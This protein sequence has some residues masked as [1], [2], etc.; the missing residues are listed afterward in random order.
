M[1]L[2]G[3]LGPLL[4]LLGSG[5]AAASCVR[6]YSAQALEQARGVALS[7]RISSANCTGGLGGRHCPPFMFQMPPKQRNSHRLRQRQAKR[8]AAPALV[9]ADVH[10]TPWLTIGDHWMFYGNFYADFLVFHTFFAGM[11][12]KT[13][14]VTDGIYVEIGGSN[15]VHASNTLFFEQQ[16]RWHGYLIEPTPCA[17]CMLP[18]TRPRDHIIRAGACTDH[19]MLHGTFMGSFCPYPQNACVKDAPGG[20]ANYSAPCLPMREI[21][22]GTPQHIDFFSIDVEDHYKALLT[23]MPWDTKTIDVILLECAD[24]NWCRSY[25]EERGYALANF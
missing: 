4:W 10:P 18:Y 8:F 25:L 17:V 12:A 1:P 15:G 5:A 22:E 16:L 6:Y 23:T 13:N 2:M 7:D 24:S 20:L 11:Y 3:M 19:A 14:L 9:K 21:L